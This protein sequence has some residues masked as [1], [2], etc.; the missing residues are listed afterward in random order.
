MITTKCFKIEIIIMCLKKDLQS[1]HL[2]K[3]RI[4]FR[5]YGIYIYRNSYIYI[6]IGITIY[7]Y[8]YM[9]IPI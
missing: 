4:N 9:V 7:I 1:S 5:N 2:I 3:Y 8:I 6:Y